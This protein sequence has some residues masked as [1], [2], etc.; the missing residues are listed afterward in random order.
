MN[1]SSRMTG[2]LAIGG[3]VV[4]LTVVAAT[5]AAFSG[6]IDAQTSPVVKLILDAMADSD[7]YM[8]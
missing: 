1:T 6:S 7:K 3:L 4:V 2:I 8:N 5:A